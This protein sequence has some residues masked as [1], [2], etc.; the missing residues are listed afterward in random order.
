MPGFRFDLPFVETG[1]CMNLPSV[2]P[3]PNCPTASRPPPQWA[4][5]L[6]LSFCL[7]PT[8]SPSRYSAI[9]HCS[10]DSTAKL[11]NG[12]NFDPSL[13]TFCPPSQ[14]HLNIPHQGTVALSSLIGFLPLRHLSPPELPISAL[15]WIIKCSPRSPSKPPS[16]PSLSN[17]LPL[18]ASVHTLAQALQLPIEDFSL[19]RLQILPYW[20]LA[21][22]LLDAPPVFLWLGPATHNLDLCDSL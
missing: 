17:A 14:Q 20:S 7:P 9:A 5:H 13:L 21:L 16:P 1:L 19:N 8:Y 3:L 15:L 2:M 10:T 11:S 12:S 6:G 22:L 18:S 4:L